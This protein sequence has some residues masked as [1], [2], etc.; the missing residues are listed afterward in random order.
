MGYYR[1]FVDRGYS[2]SRVIWRLG[3]Y[4]RV[5][6]YFVKVFFC[7]LDEVGYGQV[8]EVVFLG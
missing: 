1:D 3:S 6:I 2:Y 5:G 4:S 8:Q 7:Y